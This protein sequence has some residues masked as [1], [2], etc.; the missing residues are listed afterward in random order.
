ML[1]FHC[2]VRTS[3]VAGVPSSLATPSGRGLFF[4]RS[5][6]LRTWNPSPSEKALRATATDP[7]NNAKPTDT[8]KILIE[9]DWLMRP[10]QRF[11]V[12]LNNNF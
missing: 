7:K 9:P 2:S 8:N 5:A 11:L 6:V 10:S 1:T 12:F 3:T 4:Q